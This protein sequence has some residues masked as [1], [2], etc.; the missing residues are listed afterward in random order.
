MRLMLWLFVSLSLGNG[1][2]YLLHPEPG[3]LLEGPAK[4]YGFLIGTITLHGVAL[5]LVGLLVREH[6]VGWGEAFG[7][8][9]AGA[10]RAMAWAAGLCVVMVPVSIALLLASGHLLSWFAGLTQNEAFEPVQQHAV[11]VIKEASNPWQQLAPVA[12]EFIFRGVLYP[13]IKQAGWPRLA[14]WGT[15]FLF[16]ITHANAMT[17]VS[18]F[19]FSA[20]LIWLY[21]HT[22]NLLAPIVTHSLFNAT[23]FAWLNFEG[24]LQRL[25]ESIR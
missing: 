21:E 5:L 11:Q 22:A 2:V 4:F 7:F 24:D 25:L 13:T 20:A 12:E 14:W 23:N 8:G 19:V 16:A 18:L 1:L 15:S 17:F 10:G 3:A 9:G 6:R